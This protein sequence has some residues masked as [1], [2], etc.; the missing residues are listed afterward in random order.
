MYDLDVILMVGVDIVVF[1]GFVDCGV[2][3]VIIGIG[4]V[5]L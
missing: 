2:I 4:N 5:L 3:G 1:V